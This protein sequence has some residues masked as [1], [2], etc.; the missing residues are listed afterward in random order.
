MSNENQHYWRSN[1]TKTPV[2]IDLAVDDPLLI[3]DSYITNISVSEPVAVFDDIADRFVNLSDIDPTKIAKDQSFVFGG[4]EYTVVS[5]NQLEKSPTTTQL[6]GF[7]DYARQVRRTGPAYISQNNQDSD[8]RLFTPPDCCC[9]PIKYETASDIPYPPLPPGVQPPQDNPYS[10]D[11]PCGWISFAQMCFCSVTTEIEGDCGDPVSSFAVFNDSF[12]LIPNPNYP[13]GIGVMGGNNPDEWNYPT[14]VICATKSNLSEQEFT[15]SYIDILT[16]DSCSE[17]VY[18][19]LFCEETIALVLS[20]GCDKTGSGAPTM[21]A[22][23]TDFDPANPANDNMNFVLGVNNYTGATIGVI[24]LEDYESFV[25]NT[26]SGGASDPNTSYLD[27]FSRKVKLE[28]TSMKGRSDMNLG[29]SDS[30]QSQM[31]S[32]NSS[33]AYF[34]QKIKRETV[35]MKG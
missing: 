7:L 29:D 33:P 28:P 4:Q 8:L 6:Q 3:T 32:N 10:R 20:M 34:S 14:T 16:L 24:S 12:H 5:V 23:T 26:G 9:S 2:R 35:E 17:A 11:I 15:R 19:K 30:V 13:G 25:N 22:D 31:N 27:Y 1:N 21:S 18:Q